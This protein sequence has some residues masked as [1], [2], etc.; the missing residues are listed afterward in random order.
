MEDSNR[1]DLLMQS[2]VSRIQIWGGVECTHNRVRDLY[3][4]Q[5]DLSG[6]RRRLSDLELFASLGIEGFRFGLLWERDDSPVCRK[7]TDEA[8]EHLVALRMRPIAGLL[9]HGSGPAHTSLLDPALPEKLA[10]YAG[11]VAERYPFLDAYTPVNEPHTTARFSGYYGV[12]YPHHQSRSSFLRALLLQVKATVLSMRAIRCV[13]PDAQLVQTE[14]A[15]TITGT[16]ELRPVWELLSVRRWLTFDL[17]CGRVD[18]HHPMF[19]YMARESIPERDILWF[20]ENPCPPDVIGL[21]YYA[22]SDR[23][24]DHRVHLYPEDRRSAEG[25]FVDVETV[26]VH[27]AEITGFRSIL[28]EAWKR[29]HIPVAITEVHLGGDLDEQIRWAADAWNGITEA[30]RQGAH[31]AAITFW[32]LLGSF[33]WNELVTRANGHYEPGVFDVCSGMPVATELAE[34]IAQIAAGRSPKHPALSCEGWWMRPE[35]ICFSPSPVLPSAA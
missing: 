34:V 35:R 18:R 22:T 33:Y 28:V 17:L 1:P 9:H 10:R 24:L 20:A 25:P 31:C 19:Q 27:A 23:Y 12:W 29:Y 5:L 7:W 16:P 15:G 6:H 11:S 30:R 21:N 3:F 26:R 32:S 13:R 4:D 14:D 2:E 8:L